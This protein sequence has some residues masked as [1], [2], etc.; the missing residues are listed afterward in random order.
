MEANICRVCH[1]V[2]S[3]GLI[4]AAPVTCFLWSHVS[5]ARSCMHRASDMTHTS[6]RVWSGNHLSD[7]ELKVRGNREVVVLWFYHTHTHKLVTWSQT[8]AAFTS[9][10]ES[11]YQSGLSVSLKDHTRTGALKETDKKEEGRG[12]KC[13]V[14]VWQN[15]RTCLCVSCLLR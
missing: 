1:R 8:I 6:A 2:L 15:V 10:S 14:C 4:A 9:L 3:T 12:K 7:P 13:C 5:R 11:L